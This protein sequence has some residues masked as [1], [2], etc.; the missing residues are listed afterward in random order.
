MGARIKYPEIAV[1]ARPE[2]GLQ[3][4]EAIEQSANFPC[5]VE[6]LEGHEGL[7]VGHQAIFIDPYT[8][9]S[10]PDNLMKSVLR[11]SPNATLV[12]LLDPNPSVSA[13][14]RMYDSEPHQRYQ[15]LLDQIRAREN[16]LAGLSTRYR[17]HNHVFLG[18]DLLAQVSGSMKMMLAERLFRCALRVGVI[19]GGDL[20]KGTVK[21]SL[22]H[23]FHTIHYGSSLADELL[24]GDEAKKWP[25]KMW[26][27][28]ADFIGPKNLRQHIDRLD[29]CDSL[30]EL[31]EHEPDVVVFQ[32]SVKDKV[33]MPKLGPGEDRSVAT[34]W[35]F[36]RSAPRAYEYFPVWLE[37]QRNG[38][39]V[40]TAFSCNPPEPIAYTAIQQGGNP[41]S[42]VGTSPDAHRT[43]VEVVNELGERLHVQ[44][45]DNYGVHNRLFIDYL[46]RDGRPVVW[47]GSE[48]EVLQERLRAIGPEYAY[49]VEEL[50]RRDPDE[51]T[52]VE[53]APEETAQFL[54]NL[55]TFQPLTCSY[56]HRRRGDELMASVRYGPPPIVHYGGSHIEIREPNYSEKVIATE[57]KLARELNELA[58]QQML[59]ARKSR[60][61]LFY[62]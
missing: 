57:K 38:F 29:V 61:S 25:K 53:D 51:D 14:S 32:S 34:E 15:V 59:L 16:D 6:V 60:S 39:P 58:E 23:G 31:F 10:E 21:N 7:K 48:V 35:F 18:E 44:D 11:S 45:A 36:D 28:Y 41:H 40:L 33:K 8:F 9:S 17:F 20:G 55:A 47:E 54:F 13:M 37:N 62:G 46:T 2:W 24:K 56:Y 27:G 22:Q 42:V 3:L 43:K 1:L 52:R 26:R 49:A 19:G 12:R 50:R 5:D 4:K 30:V